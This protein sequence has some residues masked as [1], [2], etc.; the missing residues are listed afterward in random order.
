M[1][2]IVKYQGELVQSVVGTC[3]DSI[4]E[5]I[6]HMVTMANTST[7]VIEMIQNMMNYSKDKDATSDNIIPAGSISVEKDD[8]GTYY[9]TGTNIVSAQDKD[10]IEPKVLEVQ[11]LDKTGL[12]KRYKELR[13]SG[14]NTHAKG[15]GIGTYLIAKLC[16][17]IEYDFDAINDNRYYFTMRSIIKPKVKKEK[18]SKIE[19]KTILIIDNCI[20]TQKELKDTFESRNFNVL[21]LDNTTDANDLL[22]EQTVDL[23][24]LNNELKDSNGIDFLIENYHHIVNLLKISVFVTSNNITSTLLKSA[25]T[26]GAKDVLYKPYRIDEL[27]IK[28]DISIDS[29][30]QELTEK[31]TLKILNEYKNAVDESSIVTKTDPKGIITYVNDLFCNISGYSKEELIGQNHN[32][33]R[34]EDINSSVYKDMWH[35]IRELKKPWRGEI[36]NKK[37][38]GS[39]Y[40][41][42]SFVKP[43]LDI[44]KNI[45][46]YI[47]IRVDIT[48]IKTK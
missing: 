5:N 39:I 47:A 13:K 10:K 31:A 46:E 42:Q 38:D 3:M 4:E 45:V 48:D 20:E 1:E 24:I 23:M 19:L 22:N 41:V 14:E 25:L 27:T 35:T 44:D 2:E 37:K 28:V 7:I 29:R 9:I 32:I 18:T 12:K 17:E 34:H 6:S 15:G 36:K 43:I 8:D 21:I 40:W 26:N 30:I 16:D 11:S 33:V